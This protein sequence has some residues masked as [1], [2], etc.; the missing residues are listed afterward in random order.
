MKHPN[1]SVSF[2]PP[3]SNCI[4]LLLLLIRMLFVKHVNKI[5]GVFMVVHQLPV[6]VYVV[7]TGLLHV[8][9]STVP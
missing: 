6:L 7:V 8:V 9:L 4:T 5:V 2:K 1:L 3:P